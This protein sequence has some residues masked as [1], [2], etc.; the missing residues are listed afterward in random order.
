VQKPVQIKDIPVR[1][2]VRAFLI[3]EFGAEPI[4]AH[5]KN[6][7]GSLVVLVA[8]KLPYDLVAPKP[9]AATSSIQI[10]LPLSLKHYKTTPQ[11][12]DKLGYAFEKL[13]QLSLVQFIKGQVA[14][15]DNEGHAINSFYAIYNINPD[16]L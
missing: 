13:F 9:V 3:G 12:A 5:S 8:Q 7:V 6:S 1:P 4:A 2:H 14:L 15:S 16:G 11:K 10:K